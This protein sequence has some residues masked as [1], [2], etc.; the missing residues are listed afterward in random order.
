MPDALEWAVQT[1]HLPAASLRL[2]E[3]QGIYPCCWGLGGWPH[4]PLPSRTRLLVKTQP[5]PGAIS[6]TVCCSSSLSPLPHRGFWGQG[7][8]EESDVCLGVYCTSPD[9]S[10]FTRTTQNN[11]RYV[12]SHVPPSRNELSSSNRSR[13]T[14]VWNCHLFACDLHYSGSQF[15]HLSMRE[16]GKLSLGAS[17]S[18][19]SV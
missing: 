6:S 18:S 4:L 17:S 9:L 2:T 12:S 1:L 15:D 13:W 3:S 19:K 10:V 8:E 11:T 14:L 16:Y 5:A 7:E